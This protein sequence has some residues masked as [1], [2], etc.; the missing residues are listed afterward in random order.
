V[1]EEI[2]QNIT[3]IS[4]ILMESMAAGEQIA[5]ASLQLSQLSSDFR[6]EVEKFKIT[7]T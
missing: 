1:T 2:N 5:E 4:Q 6:C 7:G 3:G